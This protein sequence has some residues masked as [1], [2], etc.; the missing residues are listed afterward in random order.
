[1]TDYQA[2]RKFRKAGFTIAKK[3]KHWLVEGNGQQFLLN[4]GKLSKA[5]ERIVKK[6]LEGRRL[7]KNESVS[8]STRSTA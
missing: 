2:I 7:T 1:M 5:C 8:M 3:T 4:R 6:M